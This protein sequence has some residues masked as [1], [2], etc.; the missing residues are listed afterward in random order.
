MKRMSA[1]DSK[2]RSI[3][4]TAVS[5]NVYRVRLTVYVTLAYSRSD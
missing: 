3:Y 4:G 1:D 2:Y 5:I